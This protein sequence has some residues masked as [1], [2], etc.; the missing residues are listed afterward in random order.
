[1]YKSFLIAAVLL[2]IPV[3]VAAQIVFVEP[4]PQAA[5][6]NAASSNSDWEKIECRTQDVLGSRLERHKVCLTKWQWWT[7][8]QEAKQRVEQWQIIGFTTH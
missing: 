1:M 7:Y 6:A 5:T 2:A 4:P 8:E 3:P